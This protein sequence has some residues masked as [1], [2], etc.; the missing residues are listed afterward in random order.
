MLELLNSI[1]DIQGITLSGAQSHAFENMNKCRTKE[2]GG[3]VLECPECGT[4]TIQFNP[5]NIRG[6]PV[7][8][9]KN[10]M[11]WMRKA[12][13]K[14]LPSRHYHLTFT[15]PEQYTTVWLRHKREV[16]ESLFQSVRKAIQTVMERRGLLVG[17]VL[18]FQSHGIGMSYKPHMHCVLSSGGLDS[19]GR[20]QELDAIPFH[21]LEEITK[22]EF[23]QNIR[24]NLSESVQ[25]WICKEKRSNYR[26]Y[27][28]VHT[29][30]GNGIIQYLAGT[31]NGVVIDLE[32]EVQEV[33]GAIV[34]TQKDQGNERTTHLDTNT[35]LE[36]YL[37]HIPP[38]RTV[39]ARYY[40]L[41]S[42]RHKADYKKA[43]K[44]VKEEIPKE[45]EKPYVELCPVCNSETRVSLIFTKSDYYQIPGIETKNGPPEHGSILRIA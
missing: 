12:Q 35:Y 41:Y 42:N 22:S 25:E 6:C 39:M 17:S 27:A 40:G 4:K 26:V 10:Q 1:K 38:E 9:Q 11:Q 28:G 19:N 31:R 14:I 43:R 15:I 37:N 2:M 29:E 20:Y 36:R 45:R 24:N 32:N 16:I 7:C 21:E 3:R 23:E 30:N 44:Q 34:L 18:V 8:Y 13:K 5:C 33:G